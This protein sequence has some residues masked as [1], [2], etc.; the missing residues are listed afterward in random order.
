MLVNTTHGVTPAASE[1]AAMSNE[2]DDTTKKEEL[3]ITPGGPRPKDRVHSVG[4]GE[5]V[6]IDDEGNAVVIPRE[7]V[8]SKTEERS[9][10]MA[11]NLVLT[12]DGFRPPSLVHRVESGHAL[13]L[14]DGRVQM[15]NLSTKALID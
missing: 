8:S 3:V 2:S 13:H 9:T 11:Q 1:R 5:A 4:P 14:A 7:E 12:P 10:N 15:M 6:S